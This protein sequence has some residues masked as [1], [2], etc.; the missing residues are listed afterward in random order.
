MASG[1]QFLVFASYEVIVIGTAIYGSSD[2]TASS[3]EY[4]TISFSTKIIIVAE[5][6]TMLFMRYKYC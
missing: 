6:G 4:K 1:G 2:K 5:I 3:L